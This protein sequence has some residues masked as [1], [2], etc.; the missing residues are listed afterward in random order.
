VLRVAPGSAVVRFDGSTTTSIAP[1]VTTSGARTIAAATTTLLRGCL[2]TTAPA[3]YC[4]VPSGTGLRTVPQSLR[5]ALVGA[6][7]VHVSVAPQA[8]GR[9]MITGTEHVDGTY[10]SLDYQN[11]TTT[12]TGAVDVTFTAHS[13]ATDP[14]KIVLDAS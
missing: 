5:G 1:T 9:L 13:Y 14:L 10:L 4:P 2:T 6:P 8:D 7:D 12:V 3:A 11:Q